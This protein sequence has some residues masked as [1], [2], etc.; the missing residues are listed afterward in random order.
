M[1][2]LVWLH[3]LAAV[4]WIGGTIFL[5]VVLVPVFRREPFSSQNATLIWTTRCGSA[6]L[7]G[8]DHHHPTHWPDAAASTW[9]SD[10]ASIGM[11]DDSEH[12]ARICRDSSSLHRD[13]RPHHW[14][15]CRANITD[16]DGEPNQLRSR[17]GCMVFLD[18][19][20]LARSYASCLARRSHTC[21]EL[22][23]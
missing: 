1:V 2:L 19:P 11:A 7:S 17:S 10:H 22:A 21:A 9:N 18:R 16:S 8:R 23:G 12:Q 14:A 13:V 3:L 15:S 4:S 6:Q 5:S 20:Q